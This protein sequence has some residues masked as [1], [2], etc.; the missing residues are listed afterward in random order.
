MSEM[1]PCEKCWSEVCDLL[2]NDSIVI[3][4]LARKIRD[5]SD[6]DS[7]KEFCEEQLQRVGNIEKL[8]DEKW[9]V[10]S[11]VRFDESSGKKDISGSSPILDLISRIRSALCI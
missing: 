1:A 2:R 7:T 6:E 8:L 9:K 3:G 5:M 4:L 10:L 11:A